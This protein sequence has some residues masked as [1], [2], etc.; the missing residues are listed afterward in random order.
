MPRGCDCTRGC[1]REQP[2]RIASA[3]S[4]VHSQSMNNR[5]RTILSALA[6]VLAL[7]GLSAC[8]SEGFSQ[9]L[10]DAPSGGAPEGD[11]NKQRR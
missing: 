6:L 4:C 3:A 9:V 2:P 5:S 7:T 11:T 10:D 8:E 1:N